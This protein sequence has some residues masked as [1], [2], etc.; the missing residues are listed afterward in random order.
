MKVALITPDALIEDIGLLTDYHM[1]LPSELSRQSYKNGYRYL[2]PTNFIILDNGIAEG[3]SYGMI[4]LLDMARDIGAN[5]IVVPDV[6][7]DGL[8]TVE[9]V[10]RFEEGLLARTLDK[11]TWM[12]VAQ[13]RTFSELY[14]CIEWYLSQD[15][16]NTIGFPRA[17]QKWGQDA[18]WEAINH[19]ALDITRAG[20]EIHCLGSMRYPMEV[21]MLATTRCASSIRGIDTCMPIDL[22]RAGV[23]IS[24]GGVAYEGRSDGYFE[25]DPRGEAE[26]AGLVVDNVQTYLDWAHFSL[27]AT[28]D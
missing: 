27:G 9:L 5:E 22:A 1:V 14:S 26:A 20:K 25:W 4:D 3:T 19:W 17:M 21:R 2:D 15:W 18:R 28:S 24:Q 13:G 10:K 7:G 23:S 12:A 16:I 11:Y 6:I 8:A